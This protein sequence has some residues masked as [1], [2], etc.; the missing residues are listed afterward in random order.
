MM[1]IPVMA[2]AL[3][4]VV[5]I[6]GT[7][8]VA[9]TVVM[10]IG[11]VGPLVSP[12]DF[13][14]RDVVVLGTS[15]L[16]LVR[17]VLAV[18]EL[19]LPASVCFVEIAV[20]ESVHLAGISKHLQ[21]RDV[22]ALH[23]EVLKLSTVVLADFE[24]VLPATEVLAAPDRHPASVACLVAVVALL[25]GSRLLATTLR[26]AAVHISGSCAFTAVR[27]ALAPVSDA[28]QAAAVVLARS[29]VRR[30]LGSATILLMAGRAGH[31]SDLDAITAFS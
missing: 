31:T 5:L 6:V 2:V 30:L 26:S 22:I 18:A 8:V 20:L 23:A 9:M 29:A 3:A 24:G 13:E 17:I 7:I 10:G 4:V 11:S 16:N 21:G 1:T 25:L 12:V 14:G 15:L 28:V 19:G 27:A